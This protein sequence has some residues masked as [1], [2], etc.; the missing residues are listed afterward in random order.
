MGGN[1][2]HGDTDTPFYRI[3]T[4]LLPPVMT[5]NSGLRQGRRGGS[6]PDGRGGRGGL[7]NEHN[8]GNSAPGAAQ[9][10]GLLFRFCCSGQAG[11]LKAGG[12]SEGEDPV[13]NETQRDRI[14][15]RTGHSTW[16]GVCVP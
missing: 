8:H 9:E 11:V 12:L 13:G 3:E 7:R 10:G 5:D 6:E 2:G 14:L 15:W 4:G 1:F 16:F